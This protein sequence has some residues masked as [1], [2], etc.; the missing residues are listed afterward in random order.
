MKHPTASLLSTTTLLLVAL[1]SCNSKTDSSDNI[2]K[3]N[4]DSTIEAINTE[5]GY[6]LSKAENIENCGIIDGVEYVRLETSDDA[7]IGDVDKI[8]VTEDRIFVANLREFECCHIFDRKG[9]FI[10]KL[11]RKGRAGN[12]YTYLADI[13]YN[14]DNHTINL[15]GRFKAKIL[16]FD[17]DG[18]E[19]AV[20]NE[21]P[22]E[23]TSM[24][25]HKGKYY[26]TTGGLMPEKCDSCDLVVMNSQFEIEKCLVKNAYAGKHLSNDSFYLYDGEIFY[27]N[28]WLMQVINPK[29][30][31]TRWEFDFGSYRRPKELDNPRDYFEY[32]DKNGRLNNKVTNVSKIN[33]SKDYVVCEFNH[34]FFYALGIYDKQTKSSNVVISSYMEQPYALPFG[35]ICTVGESHIITT[36]SASS[37]ARLQLG[38]DDYGNDFTKEFPKQIERLR[39][40][41]PT[42]SE[43]DNPFIAIYTLKE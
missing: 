8:I 37:V 21:L 38:K 36:I 6:D 15:L 10:K 11:A 24:E 25:Y 35:N 2:I 7:L 28:N 29:S 9:K 4:L 34:S 26:G 14:P 30:G 32:I 18:N 3:I 31:E 16:S 13:F 23:F 33:E 12:E 41:F 5:E 43:E 22:A 39:A 42:I 40:D 27:T 17:K 1:S 20:Y 19:V